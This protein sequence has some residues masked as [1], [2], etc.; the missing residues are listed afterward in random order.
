MCFDS[1]EKE[2]IYNHTTPF[3]NMLTSRITKHPNR[4]KS[5]YN[6]HFVIVT[7]IVVE[8]NKAEITPE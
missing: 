1:C 5:T 2:I 6:K 8:S 7:A 4:Q 3:V